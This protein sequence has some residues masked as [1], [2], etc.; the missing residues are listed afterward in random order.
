MGKQIEKLKAERRAERSQDPHK[1]AE[2]IENRE[3]GRSFTIL[4]LL[5]LSA[6]VGWQ[7]YILRQDV[8]GLQQTA[9]VL[10]CQPTPGPSGKMPPPGF[11]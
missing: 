9:E 11:C 1:W 10:P 4:V 6:W 8:D 7:V 2:N 3:T 5:A